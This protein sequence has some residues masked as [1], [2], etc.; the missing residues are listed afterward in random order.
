VARQLGIVEEVVAGGKD[1]AQFAEE[2]LRYFRNLLVCKTT[3]DRALL[4][5]PEEEIAAIEER[6]ARYTL[7]E[8]IRTV[9]QFAQLTRGFDSQLAQRIALESLLIKLSKVGSEISVDTVLDK[10]LRLEEQFLSADGAQ[11]TSPVRAAPPPDPPK[12]G[13]LYDA[14]TPPASSGRTQPPVVPRAQK[15][16]AR[17]RE[18]ASPAANPKIEPHRAV[19]AAPRADS[20]QSALPC[21]PTANVEAVRKALELPLVQKVVDEFKGRIAEVKYKLDVAPPAP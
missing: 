13:A 16:P 6:A 12:A 4:R 17:V 8:L 3:Q 1:L 19:S 2:L 9:E 11:T 10:L 21:Y 5:L 15:L 18:E 14:P 7:I 20:L